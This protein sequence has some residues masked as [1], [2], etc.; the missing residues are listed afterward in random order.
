M[1]LY[2]KFDNY[3]KEHGKKTD[4]AAEKDKLVFG[5]SVFY[6]DDDEMQAMLD[7][8]YEMGIRYEKQHKEKYGD[9]AVG[10]LRHL[11]FISAPVE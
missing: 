11:S 5:S 9:K 4:K 8:I 1:D 2:L 10:K 7:E 3:S 6:L